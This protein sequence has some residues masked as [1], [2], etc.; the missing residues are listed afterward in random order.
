MSSKELAALLSRAHRVLFFTGAGIS[1]GSGIPDFRGPQGL[2]KRWRPVYYDEFMNSHEAR[3]RHW[4]FKLEGWC[5]FRDAKPNVAHM[6]LYELDEMGYLDALVT[7]NIDGLHQLAGHSEE[8]LIELHGTNRKVECQRCKRLLEPDPCFD[9]FTR[10]GE[11]PLCEC[12]GFLKPATISFGQAMP[13]EELRKAFSVA[14]R[15]DLVVAIGS[16]LEVEPAA[17]VPR[18]A[19]ENG[20][21]YVIVNQGPTGQDRLADLRIEDDAAVVLP[22]VVLL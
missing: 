22:A 1:T 5:E 19:K 17:S 8:R 6:A 3:V 9:E 2:W 20:A 4:Q 13:H 15:A 12:E 10:T 16:T 14:S 7:Q 11:P 21:T 18:A